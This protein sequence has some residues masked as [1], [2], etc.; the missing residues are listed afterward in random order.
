MLILL[1]LVPLAVMLNTS[2]ALAFDTSKLG[3]WGSLPLDDLASI[4]AKSG[5]LRRSEVLSEGNKKQEDVTCALFERMRV[6]HD[7]FGI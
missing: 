5:R 2:S 3:Q 7:R 1:R 4:I 6:F